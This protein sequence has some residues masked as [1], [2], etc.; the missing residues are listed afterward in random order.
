MS[1][2]AAW[3]DRV[4]DKLTLA[5]GKPFLSRWEGMD[6]NTVKSDWAH[7]LSG[8][9]KHPEAIAWALQNLPASFPP[10][11]MEFRALARKAP[12]AD[13]P[14]IEH[15]PA[16]K[17]TISKEIAKLKPVF[18]S[19]R[20]DYRDWARRIMSRHES[21]DRTLTKAQLDMARDALK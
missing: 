6:I 3:I 19:Q 21:G 7:E 1:L 13:V 14:R 2:P 11:V 18:E 5:Y 9:D 16:G 20:K 12:D 8:F 17:E 10:T 4:F 15:S